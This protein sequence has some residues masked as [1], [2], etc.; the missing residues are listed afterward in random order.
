MIR[1]ILGMFGLNMIEHL[2]DSGWTIELVL[3]MSWDAST[4]SL[5]ASVY[6][7]GSANQV[8]QSRRVTSRAS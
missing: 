1:D 5:F 6:F 3:H 8:K 7:R 4:G 2:D